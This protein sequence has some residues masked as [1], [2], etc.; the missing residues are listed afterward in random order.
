[1]KGIV[2]AQIRANISS[3]KTGLP[4]KIINLFDS[5]DKVTKYLDAIPFQ[6]FFKKYI[7]I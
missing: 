4:T 6:Y 3:I 2:F 5:E 7:Y 1:M